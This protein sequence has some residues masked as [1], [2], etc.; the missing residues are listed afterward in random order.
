M[1]Y[2]KMYIRTLSGK[3][4]NYQLEPIDTVK[5]LKSKISQKEGINVDQ[6]RLIFSGKQ[7]DDERSLSDYNISNDDT[8]QLAIRLRGGK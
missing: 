8:I 5:N 7:L 3:T 4:V 6:Q 2:K 1:I